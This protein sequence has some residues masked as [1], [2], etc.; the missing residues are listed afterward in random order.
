L[1]LFVGDSGRSACPVPKCQNCRIAMRLGTIRGSSSGNRTIPFIS[2][3]RCFQWWY[4]QMSM[5][6]V[7]IT[8]FMGN[9]KNVACF[10]LPVPRLRFQCDLVLLTPFR[11]SNVV[12]MFYE[13]LRV[14]VGTRQKAP[15]RNGFLKLAS[16]VAGSGGS[17]SS[18]NIGVPV[19]EEF[20]WGGDDNSVLH[21]VYCLN[22]VIEEEEI[23]QGVFRDTSCLVYVKHLS[24]FSLKETR[25][26]SVLESLFVRCAAYSL[27]G[28]VNFLPLCVKPVS[29]YCRRARLMR[30]V[31]EIH[32]KG[33]DKRGKRPRQS[34]L[35]VSRSRLF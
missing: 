17:S 1:S 31:L 4:R 11:L 5:K 16:V 27:S 34:F 32:A 19:T 24:L 14:V 12:S 22:Q 23:A 29:P 9:L 25:S 2:I 26:V 6:N 3:R 30:R 7:S 13:S 35:G 15:M 21:D 33:R 8:A 28:R 18:A 10:F 20:P